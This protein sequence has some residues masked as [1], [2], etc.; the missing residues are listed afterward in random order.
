MITGHEGFFRDRGLQ[1]CVFSLFGAIVYDTRPV[2]F[3]T[4]S[5]PYWRNSLERIFS[6]PIAQGAVSVT[7]MTEYNTYTENVK[8]TR[9][10]KD[11]L[12]V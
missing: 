5:K 12:L 2:V 4:G 3:D 6:A 8:L 11:G 7:M 10:Y 9:A 1:F